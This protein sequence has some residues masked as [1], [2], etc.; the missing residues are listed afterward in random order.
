MPFS[1]NEL[2]VWRVLGS[3][4]LDLANGTKKVIEVPRA[5]TAERTG[6]AY[7]FDSLVV[8]P[9]CGTSLLSHE[10]HNLRME[11]EGCGLRSPDRVDFAFVVLALRSKVVERRWAVGVRNQRIFTRLHA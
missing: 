1:L 6:S 11:L 10:R 9:D 5:P 4:G 2:R 3:D 8:V 7:T